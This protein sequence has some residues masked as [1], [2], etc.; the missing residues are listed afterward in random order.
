M[1]KLGIP[2]WSKTKRVAVNMS[3]EVS[4]KRRRQQVSV[5]LR[6]LSE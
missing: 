6:W 1:V 4:I 5:H 2:F 3:R